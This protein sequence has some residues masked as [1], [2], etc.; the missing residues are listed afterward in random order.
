LSLLP[1][2]AYDGPTNRDRVR[3]AAQKFV[4]TFVSLIEHFTYGRD[5]A[6]I[7]LYETD[8]PT[9]YRLDETSVRAICWTK[10]RY[11]PRNAAVVREATRLLIERAKC[12]H[13]RAACAS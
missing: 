7:M 11:A 5:G 9:W 12:N 1:K 6:G 13:R 8:R 3:A 2:D 10:Y 4:Q